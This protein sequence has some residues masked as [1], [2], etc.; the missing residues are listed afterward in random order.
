MEG[1]N[2]DSPA[3]IRVSKNRPQGCLRSRGQLNR[4][5]RG[6]DLKQTWFK[7]E[8]LLKQETLA[9]YS[10]VTKRMRSHRKMQVNSNIRVLINSKYMVLVIK[11]KEVTIL[12]KPRTRM[13]HQHRLTSI[14]CR[15]NNLLD[16]NQCPEGKGKRT[17]IPQ[18]TTKQRRFFSK[19][20]PRRKDVHSLP[21]TPPIKE[22][23]IFLPQFSNRTSNSSRPSLRV[24]NK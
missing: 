10:R 1:S 22:S 19:T 17:S 2:G 9:L 11:C 15:N 12:V 6:M 18:K 21:R 7:L 8:N 5:V 13:G 24:S 3:K 23:R 16:S 20:E 4:G 14:K